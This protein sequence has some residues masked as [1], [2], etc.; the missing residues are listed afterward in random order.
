MNLPRLSTNILALGAVQA[1][2]FVLPLLALPYLARTLGVQGYGQVVWIQ[3]VMLFGRILVDFSFGW[4]TTREISAHRH[5]PVRV[6]HL[7]ANTWAV[8]WVLSAVFAVA[9]AVWAGLAGGMPVSTYVSGLGLMLGPVLFP[10]WLFQ[11]L[12]ALK[13]IAVLQLL[14][15][16]LALPLVF[17]LV[18]GPQDLAGALLFFS[19]SAVLPGLLSLGWIVQR[20]LVHWVWPQAGGMWSAF[21]D[22]VWVFGSRAMISVSSILMPLAV[23]WWAGAEQLAY[24]SLADKFRTVVQSLLT[25]V[26]QALFPRMSWLA[27]HDRQAARQL[28]RKTAWGMGAVAFLAGLLLWAGA[29]PLMVLFGG[30]GFARGAE[31]MQ[32]LAWAP[33]LVAFSSL[34]GEQLMLPRGM[35]RPFTVILAAAFSVGLLAMRPMVGH[36]GAVGAAQLVLLVECLTTGAMIVYLRLLFSRSSKS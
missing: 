9:C 6:A 7:F 22:G 18:G 21:R 28:L 12:E 8:Q 32:W 11:G 36:G 33:L 27:Q 23:G 16:L 19:A 5:D 20:R 35:R 30:A 29:R 14:G 26:S 24:F 3:T 31:A 25:T 10:L 13:G 4:T 34:M 2:N 1:G 17:V 15:K